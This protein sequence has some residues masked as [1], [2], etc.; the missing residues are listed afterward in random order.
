MASGRTDQRG[1]SR[2]RRLSF[3][4]KVRQRNERR[5]NAGDT[6]SHTPAPTRHPAVRERSRSPTPEAE[7]PNEF[8]QNTVTNSFPALLSTHGKRAHSQGPGEGSSPS[9][10]RRRAS[11]SVVPD[12]QPASSSH[13]SDSALALL[14]YPMPPPAPKA[15]SQT[16][17]Q[18]KPKRGRPPLHR[19]SGKVSRNTQ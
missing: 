2:R 3:L 14:R 18:P 9:P 5:N 6:T 16:Q 1:M 11:V 10:T 17:P 13:R 19:I 7:E 12:S 4:D 15:H 8:T